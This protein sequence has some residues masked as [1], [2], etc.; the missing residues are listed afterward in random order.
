MK[1]IALSYML[2]CMIFGMWAMYRI[3][4]AKKYGHLGPCEQRATNFALWVPALL[5]GEAF[6]LT[7]M[8]S[9]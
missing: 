1:M 7:T 8:L 4:R 2:G 9:H 5:I 6:F 3:T